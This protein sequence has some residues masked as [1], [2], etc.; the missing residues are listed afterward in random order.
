MEVVLQWDRPETVIGEVRGFL[1]LVGYYQIFVE[2]F[3]NISSPL[4]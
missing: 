3:S 4:T 2:G 1:G